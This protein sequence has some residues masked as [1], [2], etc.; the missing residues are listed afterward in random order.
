[1]RA[2][3]AEHGIPETKYRNMLRKKFKEVLATLKAASA[4]TENDHAT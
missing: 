3:A 1:L 4:E 2:E